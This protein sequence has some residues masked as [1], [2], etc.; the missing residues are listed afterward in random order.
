MCYAAMENVANFI[1]V[2]A[3]ITVVR[4]WTSYGVFWNVYHVLWFQ[5]TLAHLC[6]V[7][8]LNFGT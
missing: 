1:T 5:F 6:I 7:V 4:G 2:L 3:P 8:S